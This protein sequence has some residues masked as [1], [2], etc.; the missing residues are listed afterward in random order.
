MNSGEIITFDVK[1]N[2]TFVKLLGSG[3]TGDTRL[4]RD[5]TTDILFAIKKYKPIK[6]CLTNDYYDR[7]VDE[8]KIL[9]NISHPNIV[10]VYNYYLYPK[11]KA[12]Y[13]QMEYVDGKRY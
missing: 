13:L 2:F 3:G 9:F 10:R 5:E 4:F 1:K 11:A 6:E 7:F 12:G 8:I